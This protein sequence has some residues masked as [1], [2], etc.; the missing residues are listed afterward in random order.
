M[1]SLPLLVA[2]ATGCGV[3]TNA[4][5]PVVEAVSLVTAVFKVEGM[6]C[7]SCEVSIRTAAGKLDGV[8][9]VDVDHVIGAAKVQYDPAKITPAAIVEAI[10]NLGYPTA[11]DE[12]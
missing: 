8:H 5:E 1:R 11:Y 12:A 7:A 2:L 9:S 10:T 3:S 4:S 6:T